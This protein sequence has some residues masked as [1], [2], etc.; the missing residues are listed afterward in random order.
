[1]R[2][3]RRFVPRIMQAV[4]REANF[5]MLIDTHVILELTKEVLPDILP[6]DLRHKIPSLELFAKTL[7]KRSLGIDMDKLSRITFIGQLGTKEK[8]A[9]IAE[10]LDFS[11]LDRDILLE[12]AASYGFP[13]QL[14][15]T[16][17]KGLGV[18]I[19]ASEQMLS[20]VLNAFTNKDKQISKTDKGVR[21]GKLCAENPELNHARLYTLTGEIDELQALPF[22][23]R[24]AGLFLH[25][26]KGVSFA[27]ITE[28]DRI[29]QAKE[30]LNSF[31]TKLK[32]E[33]LASLG[34]DVEM[35]QG[36]TLILNGLLQKTTFEGHD[37]LVSVSIR[38]YIKPLLQRAVAETIGKQLVKETQAKPEA[39]PEVQPAPKQQPT[40]QIP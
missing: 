15:F 40:S 24:A 2:S 35:D 29:R 26:K 13:E 6:E 38:G 9:A 32:S 5:V 39:K 25:M 34:F 3:T 10:G 7:F 1:M 14:Y 19:A 36:L 4:P 18:V 28:P 37:D 21:L 8:V 17:I 11:S 20:D 22:P 23:V 31:L 12:N 16:K 27:V 33:G 30:Y